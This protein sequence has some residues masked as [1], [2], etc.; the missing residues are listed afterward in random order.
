MK[1]LMVR[2]HISVA[3]DETGAWVGKVEV[4]E[5]REIVFFCRTTPYFWQRRAQLAA[6]KIARELAGYISKGV[7]A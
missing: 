4:Q 6:E 5:G 7:A 2:L 3:L 1:A